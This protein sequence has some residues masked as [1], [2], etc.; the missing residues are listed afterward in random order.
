MRESVD[1]RW[2]AES[3]RDASHAA[4]FQTLADQHIQEAYKLANAVLASPPAAQDA[5]H[6]AF[7][8]AWERWSS[9]RD[10]A[11]LN[12]CDSALAFG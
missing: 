12:S 11:R 10:P 6:D 3:E 2:T 9:L 5:V 4:A 8:Q 1:G 7:V